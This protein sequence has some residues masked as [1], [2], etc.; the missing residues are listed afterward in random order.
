MMKKVQSMVTQNCPQ[1][2]GF[3]MVELKMSQN[4]ELQIGGA[5]VTECSVLAEQ[6]PACGRC[7]QPEQPG[8]K[9]LGQPPSAAD[10]YRPV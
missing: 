9:K 3:Q 6:A 2:E 7:L 4:P 10:S 8:Q 1:S 5:E